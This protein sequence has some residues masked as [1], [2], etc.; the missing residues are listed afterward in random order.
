[1][2]DDE[3]EEVTLHLLG[4]PRLGI[5]KTIKV[6]HLKFSEAFLK[7]TDALRPGDDGVKKD[8]DAETKY[9]LGDPEVT[10]I[11][12]WCKETDGYSPIVRE[13]PNFT[14]IVAFKCRRCSKVIEV[15]ER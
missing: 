4:D 3:E 5:S 14:R 1:M 15:K 6:K 11:C 2:T 13:H 12:P 8:Y 9:G 10:D 7:V